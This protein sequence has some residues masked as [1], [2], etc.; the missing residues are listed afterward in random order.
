MY[1]QDFPPFNEFSI[2]MS[3]PDI[4]IL[5]PEHSNWQTLYRQIIHNLK[6]FHALA[7]IIMT[8]LLSLFEKHPF[9]TIYF[10]NKAIITDILHSFFQFFFPSYLV[11]R[12]TEGVYYTPQQSSNQSESAS[13]SAHWNHLMMIFPLDV[14]ILNCKI[15]FPFSTSKLLFFTG[16]GKGYIR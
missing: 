7:I 11:R 4:R 9:H 12:R 15:M 3:A 10:F 6:Q 13:W 2:T 8:D 14:D 1:I 16:K 5:S